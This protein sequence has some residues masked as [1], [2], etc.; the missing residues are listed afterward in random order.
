M[1]LSLSEMSP[2]IRSKPNAPVAGRVLSADRASLRTGS[3][4]M[5][6]FAAAADGRS[7]D[8]S[9]RA[10]IGLGTFFAER[11][12]GKN[13]KDR[14]PM[15]AQNREGFWFLDHTGDAK[16]RAFGRS[17]E[18]AFLNSAYALLSLMWERDTVRLV[19]NE[20][21]DI[22][23]E[24][25]DLPQLLVCFLEEIL[26]LWDARSFAVLGIQDLRIF[27]KEEQG[28]I[29]NAVF[30]GVSERE[31]LSLHGEVKA[32]TYNEMMIEQ[33]ENGVLVQVVVDL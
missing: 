6:L 30:S 27:Q 15:K 29:L 22:A 9:S 17:L 10:G 16:F 23:C 18:A 25:R 11:V 28:W 33:R 3:T 1:A 14:T 21:T 4:W 20:N 19:E 8:F 2:V 12:E 7:P 32:V 5:A 31:N 26:Y 13:K 24:G